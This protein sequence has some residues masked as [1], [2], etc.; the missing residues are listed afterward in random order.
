MAKFVLCVLYHNL[1]INYGLMM[2]YR[3]NAYGSHENFLPFML[4][5]CVC[6]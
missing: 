5:G 1:K 2:G 6:I 3:N 4:C